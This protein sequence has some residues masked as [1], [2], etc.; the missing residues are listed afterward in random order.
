MA[1]PP[2]HRPLLLLNTILPMAHLSQSTNTTIV[3]ALPRNRYSPRMDNIAPIQL[4]DSQ[5]TDLQVQIIIKVYHLLEGLEIRL[6]P[7]WKRCEREEAL[8]LFGGARRPRQRPK[9][10]NHLH[11][12]TG[13]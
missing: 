10:T 13:V 6:R 3:L 1:D 11:Q 8:A 4:V 2:Y 7:S 5:H 9:V 12:R